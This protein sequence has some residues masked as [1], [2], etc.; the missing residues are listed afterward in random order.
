VLHFFGIFVTIFGEEVGRRS[1]LGIKE[2]NSSRIVGMKTP[3]LI[4][5]KGLQVKQ[6]FIA[7]KKGGA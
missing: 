1:I 7:E 4:F 5:L 3:Y 2:K 6:A